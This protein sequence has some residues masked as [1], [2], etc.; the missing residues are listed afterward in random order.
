[1]A[2]I[3]GEDNEGAANAGSPSLAKN[4]NELITRLGVL[5]SSVNSGNT[6]T[7]FGPVEEFFFGKVGDETNTAAQNTLRAASNVLGGEEL[8]TARSTRADFDSAFFEDVANALEG[9]GQVSNF[10]RQAGTASI[11]NLNNPEITDEVATREIGRLKDALSFRDY[12][13]ESQINIDE[14]GFETIGDQQVVSYRGRDGRVYHQN[15]DKPTMYIP[16][17]AGEEAVRTAM[18]T[19]PVNAQ[20]VYNGQFYTRK[21]N[22]E[23]RQIES[24]N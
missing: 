2:G 21:D 14:N 16:D 23:A 15:V 13:E 18:E 24:G 3:F 8:A 9:Q 20:V 22:P 1:M 5:E 4:T 19:I 10:E 7:G 6:L 12:R 17:W 11:T